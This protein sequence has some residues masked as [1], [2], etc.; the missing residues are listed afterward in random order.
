M[1]GRPARPRTTTFYK[2]IEIVDG[3]PVARYSDQ[4]PES[5]SYEVIVR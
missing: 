5:G 4:K 2:T 3:R 1:A